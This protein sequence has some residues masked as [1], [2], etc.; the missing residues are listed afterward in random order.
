MI[1]VSRR[2]LLGG[3]LAAGYAP[4]IVRAS[5]LMPVKAH[6]LTAHRDPGIARSYFC[7]GERRYVLEMNSDFSVFQV[8]R[9]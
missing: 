7:E 3:I 6:P 9:A 2:S 5:S 4:A 1:E 8:V